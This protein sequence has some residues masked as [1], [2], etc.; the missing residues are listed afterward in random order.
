MLCFDWAQHVLTGKIPLAL[1]LFLS[2]GCLAVE[3]AR[4]FLGFFLCSVVYQI[5]TARNVLCARFVTTSCNVLIETKCCPCVMLKNKQQV[6]PKAT[7]TT[8]TTT[9]ATTTTLAIITASK[10]SSARLKCTRSIY[11]Y[12]YL[13]LCIYRMRGYKKRPE[14]RFAPNPRAFNAKR[15]DGVCQGGEGSR[16]CVTGCAY[17]GRVFVIICLPF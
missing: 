7:T 11:I 2:S 1:S 15:M 13:Y 10:Y 14:I 5:C 4:I 8:R 12:V 17:C 16:V 3:Y 9:R 6:W